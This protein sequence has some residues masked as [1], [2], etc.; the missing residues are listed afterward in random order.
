MAVLLEEQETIVQFDR[1]SN[2]MTIWT[3]ET[4]TMNRLD[5][6]YPSVKTDVA[7]G[8][9]YA[10]TYQVDKRLLSFRKDPA[11]KPDYTPKR[12]ISKENLEKLLA[13]RK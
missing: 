8:K 7:D 1:T 9:V 12:N 4:T 2:L 5:K 6:I 10:K 13:G 3:S 11:I